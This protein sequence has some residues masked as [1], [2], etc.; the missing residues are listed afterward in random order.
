MLVNTKSPVNRVEMQFIKFPSPRLLRAA[1]AVVAPV[2]PFAM[3]SG[4]AIVMLP[5]KLASI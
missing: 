3:E 1:A 2:P 5:L 4:V